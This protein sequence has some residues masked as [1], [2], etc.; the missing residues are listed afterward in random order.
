M[1]RTS[2]PKLLA[3]LFSTLGFLAAGLQ[4]TGQLQQQGGEEQ[5]EEGEAGD[6]EE[7]DP[8][9]EGPVARDLFGRAARSS[10]DIYELLQGA[11]QLI[12]LED[13]QLDSQGRSVAGMMV[14][15]GQFL[16]I[17]LHVAWDSSDGIPLDDD[18]QTGIHEF[19]LDQSGKLTLISLIGSYL[20]DTLLLEWE[21]P[22]MVR[23]F[24]MITDGA[25]L[26]LMRTDG[27]ALKFVRRA[28]RVGRSRDIFGR[29]QREEGVEIDRDIFGRPVKVK[30]S[31]LDDP[32]RGEGAEGGG[33]DGARGRGGTR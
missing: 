6:E 27:S 13:P 9:D 11:W 28:A 30:P 33:L 18:F 17:E 31:E 4:S 21:Q 32:Q 12:A 14:V 16:A 25:F 5:Q 8:R 2:N 15:S 3:L 7:G 20:D 29:T 23:E 22:G 24:R 1:L 19:V 10:D 26:T